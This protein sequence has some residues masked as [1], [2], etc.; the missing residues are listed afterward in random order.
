MEVQLPVCPY[1]TVAACPFKIDPEHF[2]TYYHLKVCPYGSTCTFSSIDQFHE[3]QYFHEPAVVVQPTPTKPTKPTKP[4]KKKD[5]PYKNASCPFS[6]IDQ[7][8]LE[9]FWHDCDY[10]LFCRHKKLQSH[11]DNFLHEI[12][13]RN[14]CTLGDKC[15]HIKDDKHCNQYFHICPAGLECKLLKNSVQESKDHVLRFKH[16]CLLGSKC[17]KIDKISHKNKMT[18]DKD[19][20]NPTFGI[21]PST[22]TQVKDSNTVEFGTVLLDKTSHEY[23]T[24]AN[25][26]NEGGHMTGKYSKIL[27]V[28]RVE[29]RKL[30]IMYNSKSLTMSNPNEKLL[31]HGCKTRQALDAIIEKDG[32]DFRIAN[33][34]GSVG[35]GAYFAVKPSYSDS[36]YVIVNPDGSKEMIIC[37]VLIG[38]TIQGQQGLQRPP[39]N[40]TTNKLYDS[41]F[42]GG[43][44]FVVFDISQA[45]PAY[46][47]HYQ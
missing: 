27:K 25:K 35:A 23:A 10:G 11:T 42:N 46:V 21:F 5:C 22:W 29:N 47:I 36:G 4:K 40:P 45:Y 19:V 33:K 34:G 43:D 9:E 8:H 37:K 7:E 24:V 14:P 17:P 18:H 32:F 44:M 12:I 28:D 30:W 26:F 41:V 16:P 3:S 39:N 20:L 31:F 2:Q 38:D 15:K 13:D 6:R 1:K